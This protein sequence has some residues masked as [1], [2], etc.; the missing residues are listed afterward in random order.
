M[1]EEECI[2][3]W[4]KV[5]DEEV[6]V[7]NEDVSTA[8]GKGVASNYKRQTACREN[9]I[10]FVEKM[11]HTKTEIGKVLDENICHVFAPDRSSFE[12][13][14]PCLHTIASTI[15]DKSVFGDLHEDDD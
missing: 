6:G 8:K 5:K 7:A 13:G 14:K 9:L 4:I 3:A 15:N 11:H 10:F 1:E 2:A 12:K